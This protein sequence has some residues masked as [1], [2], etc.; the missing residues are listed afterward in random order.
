VDV[1]FRAVDSQH[2]G[3]KFDRFGNNGFEDNFTIIV[4]DKRLPIFCG[5]CDMVEQ[6][7]SWHLSPFK[8]IPIIKQIAAPGYEA[9]SAGYL[10]HRVLPR[11]G[12]VSWRGYLYPR[13]PLQR[14]TV[15]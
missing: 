13:K 11:R 5:P 4:V 1:V 7:K 8:F 10:L 12:V 3:A 6:L 9:R 2:A 15:L 14:S